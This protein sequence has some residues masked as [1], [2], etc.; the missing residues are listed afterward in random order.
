MIYI[1]ITGHLRDELRNNINGTHPPGNTI[2]TE[3]VPS[4]ESI[5]ASITSK[6]EELWKP[7]TEL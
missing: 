3:H 4:R 5:I 1:C 6:D 7:E 2:H